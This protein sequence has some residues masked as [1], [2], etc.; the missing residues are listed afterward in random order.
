MGTRRNGSGNT[1][2]H[3]FSLAGKHEKPVGLS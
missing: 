1:E 2:G 3:G